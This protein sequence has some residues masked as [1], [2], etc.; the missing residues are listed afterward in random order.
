MG[1]MST[2]NEPRGL[3]SRLPDEQE[4]WREFTDKI[5]NDAA[6]RLAVFDSDESRWWSELAQYS[7]LL[8][9]GAAAAVI[10]L[11]LLMPVRERRSL[12]IST[13]DTYGFAPSDPLAATLVSRETPPW[14]G[15]LLA[16]R[17]TEYER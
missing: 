3:F 12:E 13:R 9:V 16:V 7:T 11:L 1:S 15:T 10:A 6:P 8:A 17:N 14:V 5:V 2:P 4:Y